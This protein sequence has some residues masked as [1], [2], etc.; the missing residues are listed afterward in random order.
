[1]AC[2]CN[3]AIAEGVI[4]LTFPL[5]GPDGQDRDSYPDAVAE[6]ERRADVASLRH[7]FAP[8]SVA[9]I[10]AS[11]RRGTVGRAIL[12]N[13]RAA[14]YAGRV[15]VVNPR[16]AQVGGEPSLASALDLPEP[17]DLAVIAVPA[18]AGASRW[19]RSAAS[20]ACGPWS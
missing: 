4:D 18:A 13:I 17:A 11:R 19:P 15:Y 7:V 6:R 10:G 5:P 3:G 8:E 2:R 20:A 14:G 12:D 1:M 9:V 16:A